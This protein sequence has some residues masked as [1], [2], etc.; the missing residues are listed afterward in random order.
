MIP[1]SI[2]WRLPLSYALIA[3]LSAVALGA[4]LLVLLRG[5]YQ[6]QEARYLRSSAETIG[7]ALAPIVA[8]NVPPK[9][10]QSQ[11]AGIAFLTQ[12]RVRLTDAQGQVLADSRAVEADG[13][14][15]L[16][17]QVEVGAVTQ[18]F[19]QTLTAGSTESGYRSAILV[20]GEGL[21]L[22]NEEAL[23]TGAYGV[24][25]ELSVVR[26]PFG[27]GLGE[28]Q[29]E[30]AVSTE[31]LRWPVTREVTG[32]LVGYVDL[33]E[34]PAYGAAIVERVAVGWAASS[35]VAV[36]LA[37]GVGWTISR[38]LTQ[39]LLALSGATARMAAGDLSAR[40]QTK[41]RDELGTLA[42]AFNRM[43]QRLEALVGTLRQFVPD[44]AHALNTPLTV[45]HSDL[46]LIAAELREPAQVE[47]VQRARGQVARLVELAAQLLD[48]SRVEAGGAE[49][50]RV[51]LGELLGTV[52]EAY[53]S[54]AEQ[55]GVS[56]R[57]WAPALPVAVQGEARQLR[58]ALA[59]VLDNAVKY[60]PRGGH[61]EVTVKALEEA[62]CLVV[63]DSGPGIPPAELPLVFERFWRGRSALDV[64]GSGLGLALAKAVVDA[65]GGTIEVESSPAG[66]QVRLRLPRK[67]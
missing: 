33:S 54:W 16:A 50:Q 2:R 35:L 65:H 34:G 63:S 22:V 39:P 4:S 15:T 7:R 44:A 20:Q 17:I 58:L 53:A 11:L 32:E 38:G 43:A 61:I 8:L 18:A 23:A 59:N 45:L 10:L 29:A 51:D 64:P 36:L 52:S 60:T 5:Y 28:A 46:A 6:Q 55:T 57:V 62:V 9:A 56:L 12:T 3:L 67:E 13:P 30:T 26:T 1:T 40:A 25:S 48:L 31:T 24:V 37:A 21:S 14:V 49:H 66:T 27:V 42:A 19:S 41:R 47:R